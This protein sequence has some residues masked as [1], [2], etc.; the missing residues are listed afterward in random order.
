MKQTLSSALSIYIMYDLNTLT[1][2]LLPFYHKTA[3]YKVIQGK[4]KEH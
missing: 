4:G 1:F 2:S 3:V